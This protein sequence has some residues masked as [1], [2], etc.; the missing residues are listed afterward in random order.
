MLWEIPCAIADDLPHFTK[1]M[2]FSSKQLKA[3]TF[4]MLTCV[5]GLFHEITFSL[6][7]RAMERVNIPFYSPGTKARDICRLVLNLTSNWFA[8]EIFCRL[9]IWNLKYLWMWEWPLQ[10]TDL[11]LLRKDQRF[12]LPSKTVWIC[13]PVYHIC[14]KKIYC[15]GGINLL[16]E[17]LHPRA[18]SW[19]P[20]RK[21]VG[22]NE[23]LENSSKLNKVLN[24]KHS[25][26]H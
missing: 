16:F 6:L 3:A 24:Q 13:P 22:I 8:Q 5:D 18:Y 15:L 7:R 20:N 23:E 1:H 21:G 25:F 10:H 17:I 9:Q 4:S 26:R 12:F 2:K 19:V 11:V 14:L